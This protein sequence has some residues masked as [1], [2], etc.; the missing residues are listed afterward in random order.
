MPLLNC[1]SKLYVLLILKAYI[2]A[3]SG[4]DEGYNRCRPDRP[5]PRLANNFPVLIPRSDLRG[6]DHAQLPGFAEPYDDVLRVGGGSKGRGASVVVSRFAA[7]SV[8]YAG[9]ATFSTFGIIADLPIIAL[10]DYDPR[11][12]TFVVCGTTAGILKSTTPSSRGTD[13]IAV[14]KYSVDRGKITSD[15]P[16]RK[17]PSRIRLFNSFL[18]V[19]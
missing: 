1:S 2:H 3:G 18:T 4:G 11:I 13:L 6:A 7:T 10:T 17:H 16:S 15:L 19:E 8:G 12:A 14:S 5:E 9:G